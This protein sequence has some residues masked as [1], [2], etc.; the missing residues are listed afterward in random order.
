MIAFIINNQ[1]IRWKEKIR[2]VGSALE[3]ARITTYSTG[4]SR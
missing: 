4:I 3:T 1:P 2:M